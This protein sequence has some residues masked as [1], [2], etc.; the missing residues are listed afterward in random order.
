M[1]EVVISDDRQ[2]VQEQIAS[3]L[4]DASA[5]NGHV[6]APVPITLKVVEG[7]EVVGGLTGTTNWDWLYIETLGVHANYRKRGLATE[8]VAKAEQIAID[9]GCVGSWVDTFSFQ[10]P[11]FYIRLGY[12]VFGE[13][14]NYPS[15]QQRIFL[16]KQLTS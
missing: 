8:L 10:V 16:K 12:E 3:I 13:I 6:Y 2:S 1:T 15:G 4:S 7:E 9:R 5:S 14:A 11:D